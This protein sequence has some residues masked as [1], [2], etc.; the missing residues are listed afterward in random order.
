MLYVDAQGAY[1]DNR[2]L[3]VETPIGLHRF[4]NAVMVKE[5]NKTV[6]IESIH[7]RQMPWRHTRPDRR[8]DIQCC[9]IVDIHTV[10]VFMVERIKRKE[11]LTEVHPQSWTVMNS[12]WGA[13][14]FVL[15]FIIFSFWD[16]VKLPL[17]VI[18]MRRR[19]IFLAKANVART[20]Y[21]QRRF[22]QSGPKTLIH[23]PL[24]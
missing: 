13:L 23:Y 11:V 8:G 14:H 19:G 7:T 21:E 18:R 5:S 10:G 6:F 15:R 1:V 3:Y 20:S 24:L 4:K 12:F 9:R 22:R 16:C 2:W 17:I